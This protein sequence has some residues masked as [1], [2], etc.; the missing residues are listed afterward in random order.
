MI[1]ASAIG[2]LPISSLRDKAIEL[3]G[4]AHASL[5]I[6]PVALEILMSDTDILVFTVEMYPGVAPDRIVVAS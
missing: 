5:E 6:V 4:E 2:E 1:G 3:R